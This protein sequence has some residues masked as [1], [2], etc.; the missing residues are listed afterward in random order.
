MSGCAGTRDEHRDT[1]GLP[2]GCPSISLYRCY[3]EP[4]RPKVDGRSTE[5]IVER[6]KGCHVATFA[7]LTGINI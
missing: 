7:E 1:E 3:G 4:Y 5:S 2:F 6:R